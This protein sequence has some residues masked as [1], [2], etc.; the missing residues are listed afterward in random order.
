MT[1]RLLMNLFPNLWPEQRSFWLDRKFN[2]SRI[3]TI[4]LIWGIRNH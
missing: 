3:P 2:G 4:E 1:L